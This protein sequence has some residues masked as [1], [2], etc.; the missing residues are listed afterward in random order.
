M[1]TGHHIG[2]CLCKAVRYRIE[3]SPLA[4][5]YCHCA[6]CRLAA[7]ASP[8]AWVVVP[9]ENFRFTNGQPSR[10]QSSPGVERTFCPSCGSALTYRVLAE[11]ATIDVTTATLDDWATFL[12]DREIWVQDRPQWMPA[13]PGIAQHW[14]DSTSS[15][16]MDT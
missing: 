2:G 12:P 4:N 16:S 6:S 3:G 5:S 13:L 9:H 14:A 15:G 11:P 10:N 7:G 1:V 8:V